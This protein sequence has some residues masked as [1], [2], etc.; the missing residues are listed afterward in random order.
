M[1]E[2]PLIVHPE[3]TFEEKGALIVKLSQ[4]VRTKG[5]VREA[6]DRLFGTQ[7]PHV[8]IERLVRMNSRALITEFNTQIF[9]ILSENASL[10]FYDDEDYVALH[11]LR[12]A[13]EWDDGKL[14]ARWQKYTQNPNP[15]HIVPE[16]RG[17]SNSP[18]NFW[19]VDR[20]THNDFHTIFQNLTPS[21]QIILLLQIHKD[22]LSLEFCHDI[23]TIVYR[24]QSEPEC[25]KSRVVRNDWNQKF[26]N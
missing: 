6:Y 24:I 16:S 1:Q 9:R 8:Q 19:Y 13:S 18:K 10:Y 17:G 5:K 22:L 14:I 4:R 11:E 23:R 20:L 21:E 25:Y 3:Y 2:A 26:W 12:H 7:L 15:H